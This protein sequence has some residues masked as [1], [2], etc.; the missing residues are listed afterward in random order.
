VALS[1]EEHVWTAKV[2]RS[3]RSD[4]IAV[5]AGQSLRIETSPGGEE[6]LDAECPEGKAWTATVIV[7]IAEMDA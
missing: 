3:G 4:P 7:E 5:S 2:V 6:I 1:L